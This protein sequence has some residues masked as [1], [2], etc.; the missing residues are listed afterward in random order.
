MAFLLP[1]P[2]NST[3]TFVFAKYSQKRDYKSYQSSLKTESKG[4]LE[5][6][7]FFNLKIEYG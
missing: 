2:E 3:F 4:I 6:N 1:L 5:Q 7:E